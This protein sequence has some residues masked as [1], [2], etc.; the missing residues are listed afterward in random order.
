MDHEDKWEKL[1]IEPGIGIQIA[2][3]LSKWAKLSSKIMPDPP[4]SP[5]EICLP[6][7]KLPVVTKHPVLSKTPAIIITPQR[8]PTISRVLAKLAT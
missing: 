3:D 6:P 8:L 2:R 7:K 1:G 4:T 5:R